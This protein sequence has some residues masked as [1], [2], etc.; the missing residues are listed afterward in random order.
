MAV[1]GRDTSRGGAGAAS[2]R[3]RRARALGVRLHPPPALGALPGLGRRR[4]SSAPRAL[5]PACGPSEAAGP[6][7]GRSARRPERLPR[8]RLAPSPRLAAPRASSRGPGARRSAPGFAVDLVGSRHPGPAG[9]R[10]GA[11]SR[12]GSRRP[13]K[14]R[15]A[16]RS[17]KAPRSNRSGK[18]AG[19]SARGAGPAPRAC[20]PDR[21]YRS[22]IRNN[23][24]TESGLF[25]SLQPFQPFFHFGRVA[26]T[27]PPPFPCNLLQNWLIFV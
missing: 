14:A 5:A 1:T 17:G 24:R 18:Y 25:T 12:S 7:R 6:M 13:R 9:W 22:A 4:R 11:A 8:P 3:H 16:P 19:F 10:R 23:P 21:A 15:A 27:E 20:P 2:A 26:A